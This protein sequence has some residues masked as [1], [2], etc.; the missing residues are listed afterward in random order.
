MGTN[1]V[2]MDGSFHGRTYC[3]ASLTKSKPCYSKGLRPE[4]GGVNVTRFP[5]CFH[6]DKNC[7]SGECCQGGAPHVHELFKKHVE[8]CDVAAILIEPVLGE[9]GYVVPPKAYMQTLRKICDEHGILLI[10]DEVQSG[11]GRTGKWFATEHFDVRPDILVMA[12]GIASGFPLSAIAAPRSFMQ[13]QAIGSV[14]GTY[15]GNAVAAAAA[16]ATIDVIREENLLQNSLDR[17]EQLRKGLSEL[18]NLKSVKIDVRGLGS[19]NAIEFKGAEVGTAAKITAK[20]ASEGVLLLTTS[21]YETI[22]FIPPLNT[23]KEEVEKCVGV[24]VDAVKAIIE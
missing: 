19:M 18:Q 16:C 8:P 23:T 10:C 2:V 20:C 11:F 22:R 9:G 4:M 5:Y 12:K 6:C 7:D 17:G 15:G 1:I 24:F 14:G 13:K 3:A 21:A